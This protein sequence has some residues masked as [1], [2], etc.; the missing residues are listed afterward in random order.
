MENE[1]GEISGNDCN[2]RTAASKN[3]PQK[4]RGMLGMCEG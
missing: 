2:Y 3:V 1:D 4:W